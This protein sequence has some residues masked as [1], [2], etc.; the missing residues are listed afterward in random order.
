M[1]FVIYANQSPGKMREFATRL[2]KFDKAVRTVMRMED[3][4]VGD[5]NRVAV[6]VLP[7]ESSVRSLIGDKSGSVFGFYS[8]R[9]SGSVAFVPARTGTGAEWD[10]DAETVLFH[11][12]AHHLMMQDLDRPYPEWLVEG[13]AEFMATVQINRDGTILLGSPPLHRAYSLFQGRQLDLEALLAGNYGK[14]S[15]QERESIYGRGWLLTHYLTFDPQRAG[16][17]DRYLDS[18]AN[19][20]P[21]L[22]AA[23]SA[24]GDLGRLNADLTRYLNKPLIAGIKLSATSTDTGRIDVRPLSKGGEAMVLLRARS[25]AGVNKT[26]AEG[27]AVAVRQVAARFSGDELVEV[28]LA[29]AEYDAQHYD[30]AE[31]AA[32]RALKANPKNTE[33]MVYKGR[34]ILGRVQSA[35]GNRSEDAVE[36]RKWFMAANRIDTE[37]PEP[38]MEYFRSYVIEGIRPNA[39]AIA[40]LHYASTLAPQDLSLRMN[41]VVQHLRDGELKKARRGLIPIAFNPHGRELAEAARKVIARIDAGDREGA[42]KIAETGSGSAP[43]APS[44]RAAD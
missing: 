40:A 28:T 22:Q 26:T 21:A 19:G 32:D 34:A 25:K 11:E 29:E 14:I 7:R 9:A 5:G 2:E 33:A 20:V 44:Q 27:H 43:G 37:D 6:Y 31:A 13:F 41:S 15:E 17:I 10:L 4:P 35:S 24:F 12:Y 16:Q 30:A 3:P 36:A 39:N 42:L 38:L 18:I 23:R 8:G 1:H